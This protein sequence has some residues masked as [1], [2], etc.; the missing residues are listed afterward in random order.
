MTFSW[1]QIVLDRY[2]VGRPRSMHR[3]GLSAQNGAPVVVAPPTVSKNK[4]AYGK[5]DVV[6]LPSF[7]R[8]ALLRRPS[9]I[10]FPLCCRPGG[11][12]A[13]RRDF[14]RLPPG[15][16]TSP[17]GL[18]YRTVSV[19]PDDEGANRATPGDA[20]P[21]RAA[22]TNFVRPIRLVTLVGRD[23]CP[24]AS[25]PPSSYVTLTCECGPPPSFV[26]TRPPRSSQPGPPPPHPPPRTGPRFA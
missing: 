5:R 10:V 18:T 16:N 22:R 13:A 20:A 12:A 17:A 11:R 1:V 7:E 19:L 26:V 23:T 8:A 25:S 6:R 2:R 14:D 9:M 3:R 4:N 15:T 24:D 21:K